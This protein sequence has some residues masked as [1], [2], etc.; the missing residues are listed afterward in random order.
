M[1]N[2]VIKKSPIVRLPPRNGVGMVLTR[3][4]QVA[5]ILI[6]LVGVIFALQAGRFILA[7]VALAIV[8]GLMLGPV[9]TRLERRG[10]P[11]W[12]SAGVTFLLFVV[13]V[14][15]LAAA[16]IG[17]LSF[18]IGELPRIWEQLQ[19]RLAQLR[20][21]IGALEG[22]QEELQSITGGSEV[23]VEVD[24]GASVED[25]AIMAPAVLAQILLFMA[26][27]YFFVATRHDIRAA[28]L[29]MCVDR[30][31]RWRTAHIFRDVETMVSRYLLSITAINL[32][33][34][35][36]VT[37]VL[38]MLD[39]PSPAL[40]GALAGLLNFVMYIG[41][42]I[43]TAILFAIGLVTGDTISGSLVP[44]L[45]Y[46]A[47][48][49]V[50]AQLVTPM[51]I[52]RTMTLNPFLVLLALAFWLW[53][54]GPIGGFIAIPALLIVFAVTRNILPSVENARPGGRG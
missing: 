18:W 16:L 5:T 47:V 30:R 4:S 23:T 52:G 11:S 32:G 20:E 49:M 42:A 8:V 36:A 43:M 10:L 44:P 46:L 37:L 6:G 14:C 3:G 31:L 27:L 21:P 54:W 34:G 40:W 7:P 45:A 17:P 19:F 15:A 35:I 51:V 22:L 2:Y 50:E 38:W 28:V 48:N 26:S 9:A 53:I 33:L 29:R 39:V 25:V 41:P 24:D 13:I 12:A 1:K